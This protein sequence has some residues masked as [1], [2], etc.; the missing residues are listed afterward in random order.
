MVTGTH[1]EEELRSP[2]L[3]RR[4]PA[5]WRPQGLDPCSLQDVGGFSKQRTVVTATAASRNSDYSETLNNKFCFPNELGRICWEHVNILGKP[6]GKEQEEWGQD[7]VLA[8]H[9]HYVTSETRGS[10]GVKHS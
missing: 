5:G 10:F 1:G 6:C 9:A 4:L 2:S 7:G 3:L 8:A